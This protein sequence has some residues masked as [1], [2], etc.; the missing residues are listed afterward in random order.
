M[1]EFTDFIKLLQVLLRKGS[2]DLTVYLTLSED[3]SIEKLSLIEVGAFLSFEDD[4]YDLS[5]DD[6]TF[7]EATEDGLTLSLGMVTYLEIHVTH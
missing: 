3:L 7:I 6:E 4:V 1:K 5:L 2:S